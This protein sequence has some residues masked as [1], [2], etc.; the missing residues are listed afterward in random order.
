MKTLLQ[1]IDG[2]ID[3]ITVTDRQEDNIKG[4]VGNLTSTLKADESDLDVRDVFTNGSYERDTIIRPL[5]DID[6]FAVLDR[7]AWKDKYGN[8]PSPQSVL[9][10]IKDYLNST[11]DYKD[12]AKQSRPCVTVELSDKDFDILPSF[13]EIGGGYSIPNYDLTGWT[14]SFPEQ[15]T[16]HLDQVH[17]Q[18]N[19]RVK[20]VIKAVKCWNRENDKII[21]SYHVEE[22][23]INIYQLNNFQNFEEAIRLWFNNA[24]YHLLSNKFKSNDEYIA[25]S[26]KVKK[27]KEK[28]N[29]AKTHYDKGEEGEATKIWKEIFGKEFPTVDTDEAKNFSKALTEGDLKIGTIGMLSTTVGKSIPASKGFFGDEEKES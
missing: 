20:Q 25:A 24:E 8:L 14:Y 3:A 1:C 4:S 15:L 26:N 5:N 13:A 2:F 29:K 23:A 7:D 16:T 19:Y 6:L 12:K 9:T 18:R 11:N 27:V 17:R 10:R 22:V 21:A 28:L